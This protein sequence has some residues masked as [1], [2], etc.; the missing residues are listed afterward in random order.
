MTQKNPPRLIEHT[1]SAVPYFVNA[2]GHQ[3]VVEAGGC[4]HIVFV[5]GGQFCVS[6]A[7]RPTPIRGVTRVWG[8]E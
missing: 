4:L 5:H 8:F 3:Y 2:P 1:V 7:R 6:G